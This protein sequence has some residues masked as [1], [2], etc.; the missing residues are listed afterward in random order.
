MDDA[1]RIAWNRGPRIGQTRSPDPQ[2]SRI[3]SEAGSDER[4]RRDGAT[5]TARRRAHR[6]RGFR[7][8]AD[9]DSTDAGRP[10]L[11]EGEAMNTYRHIAC[12]IDDSG[13]SAKALAEA[14]RLRSTFGPGRLS[15]VHVAPFPRVFASGPGAM[16]VDC[17][18]LVESAREWLDERAAMV[19]GAEA[20]LLEGPPPGVVCEWA[21]GEAVDLLIAGTHRGPLERMLLGSFAGHLV[22]H[23]PCSVLLTRPAPQARTFEEAV[24]PASI[25][26]LR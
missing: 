8:P 21:K 26:A 13:A 10:S 24:A 12:C 7:A 18:S 16:V 6:S 15:I 14:V 5:L 25:G 23:A 11:A 22:R 17:F 20:V 2:K 1:A 19:P 3:E 9:R 4:C